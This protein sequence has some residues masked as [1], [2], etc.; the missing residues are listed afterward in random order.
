[1]SYGEGVLVVD[2]E[3]EVV[4]MLALHLEAA[5]LHVKPARSAEEALASLRSDPP[6]VI[7]CDVVMPGMGG[8]ELCRSVRALGKSDIPFIFCSALGSTRERVTGLRL[9]ADDYITKPPDPQELVLKVTAQLRRT[10]R[11]RVLEDELSRQGPSVLRGSLGE[12]TAPDLFQMVDLAGLASVWV[13]IEGSPFGPAEVFVNGDRHLAHARA[14]RAEG[15]KAFFRMLRSDRGAF[16]LDRSPAPETGVS[17]GRLDR[18]LF[19]GVTQLD[20]YQKH[21]SALRSFGDAYELLPIPELRRRNLAQTTADILDLVY[22]Y[23][24]LDRVL[25]ESALTDLET[26]RIVLELLETGLIRER[27]PEKPAL[28][29][30]GESSSSRRLLRGPSGKA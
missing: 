22:T 2:D 1:M 15:A 28:P 7:V 14:G 17:L 20:E 18:C 23:R 10:R 4:E 3:R 8:Y 30:E 9:G 26:V 5:G 29:P 12:I 16:A 19:E 25:E 6:A 11:L 27:G 21:R 13:R 24:D